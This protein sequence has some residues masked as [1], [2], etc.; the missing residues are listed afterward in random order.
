MQTAETIMGNDFLQR[1]AEWPFPFG[2]SLFRLQ[3]SGYCS[4]AAPCWTCQTESWL[5]YEASRG[6]E[7]QEDV[8]DFC[9]AV[10]DFFPEHYQAA[11]MGKALLGL[12][13]LLDSEHEF[14]SEL[15]MEYVIYSL[16]QMRLENADRLGM[17]TGISFMPE[18]LC[19]ESPARSIPG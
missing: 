3:R 8:P 2:S 18:G 14:V 19:S 13:A 1:Q 4:A 17:R 12:K 7:A 10:R 6:K 15:V 16:I 9:N 11:K 5:N